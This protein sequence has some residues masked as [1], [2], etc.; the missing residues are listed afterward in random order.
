L[1]PI[2]KTNDATLLT[3]PNP[4]LG[5]EI[6]GLTIEIDHTNNKITNE[7]LKLEMVDL[8]GK[9]VVF[10]LIKIDN[11][12]QYK[13]DTSLI[14]YLSAGVYFGKIIDSN[15]SVKTLKLLVK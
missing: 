9:L 8:M 13:L 5:N 10:D 14:N 7:N 15:K 3:Y 4:L 1:K 2:S 12:N 11:S 6:S